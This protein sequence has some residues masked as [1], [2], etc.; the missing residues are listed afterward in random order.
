MVNNTSKI[1]KIA[2]SACLLG[3]NVRY[4]GGNK[5]NSSIHHIC[6]T[7]ECIPI[8]PESAIGLGTPRPAL[9]V[10]RQNDVFRVRGKTNPA[11]DPTLKLQNYANQLIDSDSHLHGYIFKSRSPSCGVDS[12]PWIDTDNQKSGTTDGIFSAQISKRLLKLPIIEETQLSDL[13]IQ[14]AFMEDVKSYANNLQGKK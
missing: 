13:N 7:F 10:I 9:M 1:I 3:H 5:N 12:T 8:C 4:D 11:F 2:V 14:K 6:N